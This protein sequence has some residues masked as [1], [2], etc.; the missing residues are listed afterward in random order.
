VLSEKI[1]EKN[2][3]EK[4]FPQ[5]VEKNTAGDHDNLKDSIE[6]QMLQL[7]QEKQTPEPV[8]KQ[9]F[10]E[11]KPVADSHPNENAPANKGLGIKTVKWEGAIDL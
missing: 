5:P 9:L 10:P 6:K 11:P 4:A 1:E 8:R 7:Q 2:Q 3:N